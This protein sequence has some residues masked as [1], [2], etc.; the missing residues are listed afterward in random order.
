MVWRDGEKQRL[1][2]PQGS[3]PHLRL[4]SR[5][6]KSAAT[7]GSMEPGSPPPPPLRSGLAGLTQHG[8]SELAVLPSSAP[9]FTINTVTCRTPTLGRPALGVGGAGPTSRKF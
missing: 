5:A 8:L 1:V 3:K 2:G 9:A 7:K 4:C 6:D